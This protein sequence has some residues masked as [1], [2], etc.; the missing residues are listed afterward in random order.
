MSVEIVRDVLG[1][2]VLINFL[3]LIVW[4]LIFTFAHDWVYRLHSKWFNLGVEKFD[5][6]QY[7]AMAFYKLGF[8]ALNL[9]PYLAIRI[10]T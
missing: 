7:A 4:F 1:W 6:I 5:A 3:I 9:V 10:V 8:I 2:C